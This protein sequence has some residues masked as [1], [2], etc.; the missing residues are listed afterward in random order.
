MPKLITCVLLAHLVLVAHSGHRLFADDGS[1][2]LHDRRLKIEL[3]AHDPHI[4][5]P[6]GL[7][8]DQRG[9]VWVIESNTHF[10]PEGY[11]G[12]ASDRLLVMSD[13]D[14]DGKA[15]S[16][17]TYTDGLVHAMSV[18]VRPS[19]EVFVATRKEIFVFSDDNDDL[20]PDRKRRVV[21]LDT[22][23]DYPHNGLAGFAFDATGWMYFGCGENLGA[24]YTLR[25][26][27]ESTLSGGGEGG[28]IYRCRYDGTKLAHWA[29]GFWNPHASCVDAFG[30]LFTV[31]NDPDDSP[32][33]R[34]LHIIEGGD[35]GYRYRNG[36]RGIHPFTAWD[37]ELP[38]TLPMLAGTGE[39]PC[40]VVA[41]ESDGL[42]TEYQGNLL[43]TSWGDHR[44]DRFRLRA[45]GS[46]LTSIAEPV[47]SGG[48]NFRPVGL[49]VA[50]DGSFYF[51][52]WVLKDYKL[53]GRGRVWRVSQVNPQQRNR[54]EVSAVKTY[55]ASKQKQL[56]ESP[57]I[58]VRRAAAR[59]LATTF[60][61]ARKLVNMAANA[62]VPLRARLES[63][64]AIQRVISNP[65]PISG[66]QTAMGALLADYERSIASGR[67][68][69]L[70]SLH[71]PRAAAR[72]FISTLSGGALKRAVEVIAVDDPFLSLVCLQLAAR[73][74]TTEQFASFTD[75]AVTRDQP[76]RLLLFLAARKKDPR[77]S[78][79]GFD[80]I[81]QRGLS[82]PDSAIRRA[83]V[84]WVGEERLETYRPRLI[85][86]LNEG[87][88]T[89]DLFEAIL[90]SF[91]R[92]DGIKRKPHE[93][94]SG[95]RY[96]LRLLLDEG[97]PAT[98]R[99]RALRMLPPSTKELTPEFL[100]SLLDAADD[101]LALETIRTL[102][103]APAE[104]A[105]R[106]LPDVARN[107][108][109]PVVQR[110]EAIVGL[111]PVARA[112]QTDGET[113][114]LLVD[115]LDSD[116]S[117]VRKESV[118]SL[119]G[120]SN[121]DSLIR[122]ALVKL[123]ESAPIS[124]EKPTNSERELGEQLVIAL[125]AKGTG[126]LPERVNRVISARPTQTGGWVKKLSSGGDPQG[127]RRTF[128][129]TNGAGCFRCHTVNGRGGRIGP[130]L[131]TVARTM[132][133]RKLIESIVEP[134]KE[135]APQFV[136]WA[137][138]TD[139]GLVHTGL[140]LD[141]SRDGTVT[142]GNT[143]GHE[144][145][146]AGDQIEARHAQTIS[147]MPKNLIDQMTIGELRDVLAFL[148]TLK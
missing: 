110:A 146:I 8:V 101:S 71:R 143:E 112:D 136:T 104:V 93:E 42:P 131:S 37:G 102:Q 80:G 116:D 56:L 137:V 52:D 61:G 25:G 50:P 70:D 94:F 9:R 89:T 82:D 130:D 140:I 100:K 74:L 14:R 5:T 48:E 15:E 126:E 66:N 78:E 138:V 47:I 68:P 36:R 28:N 22:P 30:R 129:H 88:I 38:G 34:L 133:R 99:A 86:M 87:A 46:S 123:A 111:A 128:F 144:V 135:I 139:A 91:E 18:A 127:G 3:F 49:A 57:R 59:S 113:R 29:T 118:R 26:S 96:V 105:K 83:A 148:E 117:T 75:S 58:N 124:V 134:S 122:V 97:R 79:P 1:P 62:D 54:I 40:A 12:H 2:Q 31:D 21:Y 106:L 23:G 44:I 145:R 81:I 90:A 69:A 53:H 114:R 13:E 20:K 141:E 51:S 125:A 107:E 109:R 77:L 121:E 55:D 11:Q 41:Y 98:L 16:I 92:L 60:P 7:D 142:L 120:L 85:A 73:E 84:Q 24:D 132:D 39:A 103:F 76:T 6:T 64:W 10:P 45:D 33:C 65:G 67:F 119:R 4:V 43:V 32:P 108:T 147:A 27:D 35:Y 72:K 115:L 95:S 17:V 19:G 63:H